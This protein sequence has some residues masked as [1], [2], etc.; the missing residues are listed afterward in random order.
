MRVTPRR[1]TLDEHPTLSLLV[2]TDDRP[3]FIP[4]LG[5]NIRKQEGID[6]ARV[7]ILVATRD[8]AATALLAHEVPV[9]DVVHV[10]S[11]PGDRVP[12]K[13]QRLLDAA[14]GDVI[15]WFDDD[16]WHSPD[17]LMSGL[18]ELTFDDQQVV[19][20]RGAYYVS[21]ATERYTEIL[22]MRFLPVPITLMAEREAAQSVD[23]DPAK[24]YGSDAEWARQL[25][26][27]RHFGVLGQAGCPPFFFALRHERNMSRHLRHLRYP[28]PLERLRLLA[29]ERYWQ[30]TPAQLEALRRRLG[31]DFTPT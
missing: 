12:V 13:R 18:T 3:E 8:P 10:R 27:D 23:F 5:W 24:R 1:Q 19:G 21:L 26:L 16:D 2:C 17:R 30:D 25:L 6:F 11:E 31:L 15:A 7:E 28:H 22:S 20:F 29:G 14:Q 4:W 9:A